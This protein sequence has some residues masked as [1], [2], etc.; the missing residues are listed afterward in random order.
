MGGCFYKI[1]GKVLANK[2]QKVINK[3]ISM[4]QSMFMEGRHLVDSVLTL[5]KFMHD[6]RAK[7]MKGIIFK[8]NFKRAFDS[9]EWNYLDS[10]Q[11]LLG[12]SKK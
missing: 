9:V 11:T 4:S 1:L 6:M 5:N 8:A 12:F 10:M 2:R 7:K 3:V